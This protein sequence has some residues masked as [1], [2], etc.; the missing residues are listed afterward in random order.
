MAGLE[1]RNSQKKKIY[2]HIFSQLQNKRYYFEMYDDIFLKHVFFS[3]DSTTSNM[4]Y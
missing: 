1:G 3:Y 4:D 2:N